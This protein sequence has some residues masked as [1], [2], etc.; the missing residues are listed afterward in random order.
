MVSILDKRFILIT[1]KGGVGRSTVAASLAAATARRGKRTLLYQANA[2]DRMGN[3][4]GVAPVGTDIVRLGEDIYA[5]NTNPGAALEE[6]GLMV[7]RFK[8]IYKLVFE[9][10]VTKYFL[11]AIPGLDDYSILGKVWYHT[12]EENNKKPVWDTVIFDM[13]ASGHTLSMLR[14]PGVILKTVPEGPLTRDARSVQQLL[15]DPA[16]CALVL[17]TLAEEMPA[18]E[19]RELATQLGKDVGLS[20][21]RL[22]VNQVYPD[23]FP[24][25]SPQSSVLDAMLASDHGPRVSDSAAHSS[26][27]IA[28][29]AAH[30]DLQRSRRRL[31]EAYLQELSK[32]IAASQIELP[33]LFVPSIGP[34]EIQKLSRMLEERLERA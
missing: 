5:V 25:R 20:V 10:R 18:N 7:L 8:R 21:A 31:N 27:S 19:S 22:I 3:F 4:F 11:R 26:D 14:L 29:L 32:S 6:Y 24:A 23:R 2:K 33:Y 12:T 1:G 34:A 16:R 28:A 30:A 13:P 15:V 9:N 17:V